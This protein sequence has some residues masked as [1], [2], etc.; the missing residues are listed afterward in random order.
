MKKKKP[1]IRKERLL[2]TVKPVTKIKESARDYDRKK[3]KKQ[4]R[5]R[6]DFE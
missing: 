1:S 3:L 4:D 2:W 6:D 5:K